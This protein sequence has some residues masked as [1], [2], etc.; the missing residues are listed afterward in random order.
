M[1]STV[2]PSGSTMRSPRCGLHELAAV[3]HRRGD[4][5]HLQ[6]RDR[7]LVLADGHAPDVDGAVGGR[8][9]APVARAR[10]WPRARRAAGRPR[11]ARPK[12]RRSMY[13]FIVG[14][15]SFSPT[16][17]NTVLTELRQRL[18]ERDVAEG[19]AAVVVQR[20]ARDRLAV[21]PADARV[22][23]VAARVDGGDRGDDLE[24]RARRVARLRGAV[25]AAGRRLS[26][27]SARER[28]LVLDRVGVVAGDRR[29][30]LDRAGARV[31]RDDRALAPAELLQRDAL[32][33][34]VER[35]EQVVALLL[36]ARAAGR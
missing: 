30:H 9:D 22:G 29:H 18:G 15:P 17:P 28:A 33:A 6:R 24:R 25:R 34:R 10:R 21:A 5:R 2:R 1:R 13:F 23:L 4:H 36:G 8:D 35:R 12:P 31:E 14:L 26:R 27:L 20:D 32:R 11:P 19:L 16:S 7:E 3:G